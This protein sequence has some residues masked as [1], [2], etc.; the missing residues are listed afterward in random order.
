MK[1]ILLFAPTT[2][3]PIGY[4]AAVPVDGKAGP[5]SA[6]GALAGLDAVFWGWR[7]AVEGKFQID[8]F[9]SG[10]IADVLIVAVRLF[11]GRQTWDQSVFG[12]RSG[13][14]MAYI[15][16]TSAFFGSTRSEVGGVVVSRRIRLRMVIWTVPLA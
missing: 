8:A 4:R 6:N 16:R 7:S 1:L 13:D 15:L 5:Y 2:G 3:A 9:L 10:F 12:G 11:A 14:R